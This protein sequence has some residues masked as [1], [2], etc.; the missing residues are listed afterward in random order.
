M[1]ARNKIAI[2]VVGV[3][4]AVVTAYETAT[5]D[6]VVS[7]ML[8][9]GLARSVRAPCSF[10]GA[11][12]SFLHGLEVRGLTVLDPAD[13]LGL[14][15]L[16]AEKTSVNYV[17]DVLGAGPHVTRID[18]ETPQL[19]LVRA[20]DGT[21]PA[22]NAFLVPPSEDRETPRPHVHLSHGDVAF[23][24]A[25]ILRKP[26]ALHE[27]E[28]DITPSTPK[29]TDW[30]RAQVHL[31]ATSD[32][33]GSVSAEAVVGRNGKSVDVT[34]ELPRVKIEPSL[35]GRFVGDVGDVIAGLAPR[36]EVS[37]RVKAHLEENREI[38]ADVQAELR[39]VALS[40]A[41]P[42]SAPGEPAPKPIQVTD[43]NCHL[44]YADDRLESH[45]L[46]FKA[47]GGEFRVDS[48][49]D[50][51]WRA[52]PT[53][54]AK[55]DVAALPLTRD[56]R[57]CL[58]HVA[59]RIL[60]AYD[61]TG[62]V[63]AHVTVRGDT[64]SPAVTAKADVHRGHVCY[65][66]YL[67]EDGRHI[68]F[69]W[70]ADD[71]EGTVTFDGTTIH[72]EATGRHGP[73]RAK[74]TVT[75]T[76][77]PAGGSIPEVL[78]HVDEVPLDDSLRHSFADDGEEVFGK[79]G[80]S[81]TAKSVV[82][83]V[84]RLADV[85]D[86]DVIDV[87]VECDGRA[88]F[89]PSIL[90]APVTGASGRVE[91]LEPV[92]NG[93]L[94]SL[95][96]LTDIAATGDGYSIRVA[97]EVRDDGG[98]HTQD[99]VV[100]IETPDA[101]GGLRTAAL[102][103]ED[104]TIH[105]GVK[106]AIR[107]L[108]PSG[109]VGIVAHLLT[110][111]DGKGHDTVAVELRGASITGWDDI[112]LAAR[113]LTGRALI[114][115]DTL[116]LENVAGW[117]V[118]GDWSPAFTARGRLLS[119]SGTPQ[120]DVHVESPEIPLGTDLQNSLGPLAK[121][122]EGF[123]KQVDPVSGTHAALV[124]DLRPD[125]DP[126]PF[127]IRLSGIRGALRPLGLELDCDDGT[128]HSDGHRHELLGLDAK[129]GA[130]DVR[131]DDAEIAE[132]GHVTIR[133]SFRALRFP[134]DLEGPLSADAVAKIVEKAP[135]RTAHGSDMVIDYE[136]ELHALEIAGNLS[137]RPRARRMLRDPG[138]SPEGMLDV[139]RLVFFMPPDEPA[140]FQGEAKAHEFSLRS[141]IA[142][143]RFKGPI[144]ISG[145]F[146]DSTTFDLRTSDAT[147]RVEGYPIVDAEALVALKPRGVHVDFKAKYM[148]GDIEGW[149]GPGKENVSYQGEFHL[150]GADLE[151]AI[152]DRSGSMG[153]VATGR[154]D[155]NAR[156]QTLKGKDGGLRG[157]GNLKAYDAVLMQSPGIGAI[158]RF[159]SLGLYT[160]VLTDAELKFD[161]D[162]DWLDVKDLRATGPGLNVSIVGG[163][164]K[165]GFDGRLDLAVYPRVDPGVPIFKQIAYLIQGP[166]PRRV[167]VRGTLRNP[168]TEW[169][170]TPTNAT[171]RRREPQ[172]EGDVEAPARSPW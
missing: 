160:P 12:F 158:A 103:A 155:L 6:A 13:P 147:L 32:V 113:K 98:V 144:E 143:D 2:V 129:I 116:T 154:F 108:G 114:A 57:A 133:G 18:V 96:R 162:D 156:F 146:G 4:I 151:K 88:E 87:T 137:I 31:T 115:D 164:G 131:V 21:F 128:F 69:P 125:A 150:K 50:R 138:L 24:D 38:L 117:F 67:L 52:A 112:P 134:E 170:P 77:Q 161:L 39:G 26:V 148:D 28:I 111:P 94:T 41:I 130:A 97:G 34:L 33:F 56:V 166:V 169:E 159:A 62:D 59:R 20:K 85:Q 78:V 122:A 73:A 71:V 152:R 48:T 63:D 70:P 68:G 49:V 15:L 99:L 104:E 61:I 157:D 46:V 17:L 60:A 124:L 66:G 9:A 107:K 106:D 53:I 44:R 127:E 135:G 58:P 55:V 37:A 145:T 109:P 65:D 80:P 64:S 25:E 139:S 149:C 101:G 10:E 42:E 1:L 120:F 45:D 40:V 23:A 171:S 27:I 3:G 110:T 95:V 79:W 165:I 19:K 84:Y 105:K 16:A 82:V 142:I 172:P 163:E 29:A 132:S 118:M 90:H 121:K 136:P 100:K 102:G 43:L 168:T 7:R 75:V 14:P 141:G 22:L 54:E 91:I 83:H 89:L 72:A 8:R 93:H 123:W 30:S 51:L 92:V 119:L 167:R 35:P 86:H 47:L 74:A 81:G 126:T 11:S 140:Y 76:H 36:G 153:E 5:S